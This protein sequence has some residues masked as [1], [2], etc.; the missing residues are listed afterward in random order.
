V[1][2][3]E[4]RLDPNGRSWQSEALSAAGGEGLRRRDL[5]VSAR[6]HLARV[7]GT[8]TDRQE[9]HVKANRSLALCVAALLLAG[10]CQA[11]TSASEEVVIGADLELSGPDA[12]VGKVYAQALQLRV[13]ELNQSGLLGNRHITLAIR[14]NRSD[15]ATSAANINTL[16]ADGSVRAL[17]TGSCGNCIVEAAKA[18]NDAKIP[19]ISLARPINVSAPVADRK[20]IFKLSPNADDDA[21]VLV[22]ELSSN[23]LQ[24]VAVVA[25]DD[26]FGTDTSDALTSKFARAGVSTVASEKIP[27]GTTE[28]TA[29]AARIVKVRPAAEAVLILASAPSAGLMAKALRAEGFTGRLMF[30]SAAADSLFLTG[31]TAAALNGASL[32]FTPTLVSDDIIATS[33]AKASRVSWFRNYMS[34]YGTYNAYASFAADAIGMVVEA[35]DQTK[36]TDREMLRTALETTRLDGLSGPIRITPA[37]H[38]GLMPQAVTL[39]VAA[40]GRWRLAS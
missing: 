32:V 40:N 15:P 13:D 12:S 27:T 20:Y 38:S 6:T 8:A 1:V 21:T 11:T 2:D 19:T 39:L 31:D 7:P 28:V 30:G 26:Q 33:P 5:L 17:V 29:A 25:P 37:N 36:S 9:E 10:G 23:D 34:A 3:L 16:A 35:I 18:I 4:A 24:K 22:S 14:D